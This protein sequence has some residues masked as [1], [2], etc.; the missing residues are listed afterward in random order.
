MSP[1]APLT[2]NLGLTALTVLAVALCIYL[3][4]AMIH[5]EKF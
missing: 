1:L 2:D 5:P 3:I 4:Y